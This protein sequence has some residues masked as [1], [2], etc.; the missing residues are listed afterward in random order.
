M[1]CEACALANARSL[2]HPEVGYSPPRVGSIVFCDD[3]S[4]HPSPA[5]GGI[6]YFRTFV[7]AHSRFRLSYLLRK[8]TDGLSATRRFIAEFNAIAGSAAG[9]QLI[10]RLHTDAGSG[11]NDTLIMIRYLIDTVSYQSAPQLVWGPVNQPSIGPLTRSLNNQAQSAR[12][13]GAGGG[14][15]KRNVL[16]ENRR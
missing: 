16:A 2:S 6:Y 13:V 1:D 8:R 10:A 12:R 15:S 3:A 4:P 7:D 11:L 14:R 9:T 5:L